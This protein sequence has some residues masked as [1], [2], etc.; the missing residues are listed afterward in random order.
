MNCADAAYVADSSWRVISRRGN[1]ALQ[2][3]DY[4]SAERDF[5]QA[6]AMVQNQNQHAEEIYD[7]KLLL[8]ETYRLQR[9]YAEAMTILDQLRPVINSGKYLDPTMA[10]RYWRRLADIQFAQGLAQE[11]LQSYKT[12]VTL[13]EKCF[14]EGASTRQASLLTLL[15]LATKYHDWPLTMEALRKLKLDENYVGSL[16]PGYDQVR[17]RCLLAIGFEAANQAREKKFA[18]AARLLAQCAHIAIEPRD[19]VPKY[20]SALDLCDKNTAV[21]RMYFMPGLNALIK[22]IEKRPRSLENSRAL[23]DAHVLAIDVYEK[24]K[25]TKELTDH[26]TRSNMASHQID[27][28]RSFMDMFRRGQSNNWLA[29]SEGCSTE[30]ALA[31]VEDSEKIS[32]A[33]P[34]WKLSEQEMF[35]YK[36]I[37]A[38]TRILLVRAACIL[39]KPERAALTMDN[40]SMP[41]FRDYRNFVSTDPAR[42]RLEIANLFFA[43]K[44]PQEA[45]RQALLAQRLIPLDKANTDVKNLT[46][47]CQQIL[48]ETENYSKLDN[49]KPQNLKPGKNSTTSQAGRDSKTSEGA[50]L[51]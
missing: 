45:R 48:K 38:E 51:K 12:S 5:L 7:L 25:Q 17:R 15:S 41:M 10:I 29:N 9:R 18:D 46:A 39:K 2:K 8:V 42:F 14:R 40:L 33:I 32:P 26:W 50:R 36:I 31:L 23:I 47:A 43:Q 20:S 13:V 16:P 3:S 24:A 21:E 22:L 1:L 27:P 6:L 35:L 34:Q 49:S 19:V 11:G 28:P 30:H 44:K 4:V 37:Y